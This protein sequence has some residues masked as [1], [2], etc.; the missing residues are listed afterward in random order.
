MVILK[1]DLVGVKQDISSDF[2]ILN[3]Y[4]IPLITA[5]GGISKQSAENTTHDWYE[6]VMF[7]KYGITNNGGPVS[8]SDTSVVV[9]DAS[10]FRVGHIIQPAGSSELIVVTAT[11]TATNTLTITRAY[12]GTTAAGWADSAVLNIK[13]I[14]GLEGQ[15]AR[16]ARFKPQNHLFNYT[17]IF[18]STIEITGTAAAVSL[19]NVQNVFEL[20]RWK[21]MKELGW[22]LENALID[23][24]RYTDGNTDRKMGGIRQRIVT[25]ITNAATADV[26]LDLLNG[27]AQDV[28]NN[29][30][31]KGGRYVFMV[32]DAQKRKIGNLLAS[33][34]TI[35]HADTMRG[36][37]VD[38]IRT[39][40]G[41]IGVMANDNLN[42]DEIYLIDL[43]RIRVMPLNTRGWFFKY[44]GA[45]GDKTTGMIV[46][47]YTSEFKQEK[48]HGRLYNLGV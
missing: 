42:A 33:D 32:G 3:P 36:L 1:N 9:V 27:L 43:Q 45:V 21:E 17:Q 38:S 19:Q 7:P 15:N 47:E 48:A 30:G 16:D 41:T 26:T 2:M 37:I 24:I 40:F 8:S 18:D 29:G 34:I 23:G 22:Q 28:K 5:I 10:D 46:G 20:Q 25:N 44:M 11:N 31:L 35:P 4:D 12:A 39:D 13:F 14:H 6:D